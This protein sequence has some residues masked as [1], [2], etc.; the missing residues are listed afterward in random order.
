VA[1]EFYTEFRIMEKVWRLFTLNKSVL[2]N[3]SEYKIAHGGMQL[4][5]RG[6]DTAYVSKILF[7]V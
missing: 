6:L 1:I 2:L 7:Q 5:K 3:R 4:C